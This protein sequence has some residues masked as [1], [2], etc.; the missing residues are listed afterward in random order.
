MQMEET[1]YS[2]VRD[3]FTQYLNEQ[4]LRKTEER[5]AILELICSYDGH[6]DCGQLYTDMEK[7]RFHVS[8]ATVYNTL[9]VLEQARLVVRHQ[10]LT[11]AVQYELRHRALTHLHLI[12]QHCG[13]IRE[14]PLT[15]LETAFSSIRMPRFKPETYCLYVYGTCNR[16]KKRQGKAVKQEM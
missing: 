9:D 1:L 15:E 16:C 6:F 13:L 11:Q 3:Q 8:R 12:C 2:R 14:I 7:S 4:Q 5:Y 10:F